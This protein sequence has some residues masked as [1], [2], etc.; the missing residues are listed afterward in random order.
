MFIKETNRN[1]ERKILELQE[2][3]VAMINQKTGELTK[4]QN[5]KLLR[6]DQRNEEINHQISELRVSC[7]N[8]HLDHSNK[9]NTTNAKL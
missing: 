8:S 2:R 4:S 5:E 1:L 3:F 9:L 6:L 7:N